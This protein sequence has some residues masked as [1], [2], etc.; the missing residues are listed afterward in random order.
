MRMRRFRRTLERHRA[1]P[2]M[3]LGLW[4]V[5]HT[6]AW[7]APPEGAR[8]PLRLL[9]EGT[10]FVGGVVEPVNLALLPGL[11]TEPGRIV[12]GQMFVHYRVPE[13][14]SDSAR[15]YPI[16]FIHGGGLTGASYETTPDGREGWATWFTRQGFTTYVVDLPGRGRAGFNAARVEPRSITQVSLENAWKI[17]RFGPRFGEPYPGLQFPVEALEALGAQNVPLAETTLEGGALATGPRAITALIER[18]GPAILVV[19]SQSGPMADI[20]VGMMGDRVKAVV[21]VEGSQAVA[22]TE[23]Q[24]QQ[25]RSVPLLELFGD[26]IEQDEKGFAGKPRLEARRRVTERVNAEGGRA[27]LIQLPVRGIS[28]NTHMMMQDRNNLEVAGVVLD[29]LEH[30]LR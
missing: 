10:F 8:A 30:S 7:A 18:I 6:A 9:D 2:A 19:H 15:P 23:A 28:G 16:V 17:F 4:L 27:T 24:V 13:P 21:D 12:A 20:V 26:Y 14:R 25:Y 1:R 22:P 5:L 3:S 11:P 29:W